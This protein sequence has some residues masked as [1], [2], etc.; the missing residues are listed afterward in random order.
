MKN[1]FSIF[2]VVLFCAVLCIGL[3]FLN[4]DTSDVSGWNPNELYS[5]SVQSGGSSAFT[6]ATISGEDVN[7]VG[8][9]VSMRGGRVTSSPFHHSSSAMYPSA[10]SL[11]APAGAS[12]GQSSM[13]N[14]VSPIAHMT[15]SAEYRSFGGGSNG[16][17]LGSSSSRHYASAPSSAALSI[18]APISYNGS[19]AF[20]HSSKSYGTSDV[21]NIQS[22]AMDN[23][24]VA[25]SIY[26]TSSAVAD[27]ISTYGTASYDSYGSYGSKGRS[28]VRGRQN[29]EEN[30]P[31]F[32][33]V[34]WNWFDWQYKKN[35]DDY[36][37][38]H[39]GTKG[40]D[41]IWYFTHQDAKAA[42]EAWCAYMNQQG[43]AGMLPSYDEWL[44]WFMNTKGEGNAYE[45]SN[46][47]YQFIPVGNVLPLLLFALLYIVVLSFK[48]R[49]TLKSS[50]ENK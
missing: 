5:N 42:Y 19:S 14:G 45:G 31:W 29:T 12:Y 35:G 23:P 7:N 11:Y 44:L 21:S 33:D 40:A 48:F 26:G 32:S 20:D 30:D 3:G 34:W 41:G 28:N 39:W 2:I 10:S 50:N 1:S 13:S 4:R 8:V 25:S 9:A 15:S 6:D 36:M 27:Y 43:M 17:A 22:S 16:G 47:I 46:G 24:V 37:Y 18:T 49:K 38:D